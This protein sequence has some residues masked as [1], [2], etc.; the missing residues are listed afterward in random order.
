M[1][2]TTLGIYLASHAGRMRH[3][4]SL[5]WGTRAQ[6]PGLGREIAQASVTSIALAITRPVVHC[7]TTPHLFSVMMKIQIQAAVSSDLS[8]VNRF[9]IAL[10]PQTKTQECQETETEFRD[11]IEAD[12]KA[13]TIL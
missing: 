10:C 5:M 7:T 3:T 8:L 11:K 12:S 9:I 1:A 13:D 4:F 6:A 2:A